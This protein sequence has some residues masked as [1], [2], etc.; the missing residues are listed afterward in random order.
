MYFTRN[1]EA[2]GEV[3]KLSSVN[4]IFYSFYV[5]IEQILIFCIIGFIFHI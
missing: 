1:S 3:F 4:F 2:K 5:F